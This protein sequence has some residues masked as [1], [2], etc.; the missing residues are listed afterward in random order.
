MIRAIF[1]SLLIAFASLHAAGKKTKPPQFT[2]EKELAVAIETAKG[3]G[4]VLMNHWNRA[5]VMQGEPLDSV[6]SSKSN[7]WICKK[8]LDAYPDYGFVSEEKREGQ[9]AE[10]TWMIDPLDGTR[11]FMAGRQDFG[12][13]IALLHQGVPVLG[14]NYYPVSRTI[15]FAVA[16]CGA[17]K[18]VKNR[19]FVP[20]HVADK[21]KELLPV[22]A[23]R[24]SSFIHSFYTALTGAPLSK[25]MLR[26]D[27]RC[28]ESCGLSICLIAEGK[29]TI[30]ASNDAEGSLWDCASG[31]VI[32]QEAGGFI[33]D[34][35]GKALNFRNE[36]HCLEQGILSCSSKE[37]FE[38][39]S[40]LGIHRP[41]EPCEQKSQD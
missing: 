4:N 22:V 35:S 27:F 11:S 14:V 40:V 8:L 38:R 20:I 15:Y 5:V 19:P 37:L 16:G 36:S 10:W 29:R 2:H 17:F 23:S 1:L 25:K 7:E 26:K 24:K 39:A 34:L 21:G 33:S 13:H 12:V 3:A 28:V 31:Y 30:L 41:A 6:A 32:L 18:Q 9:E